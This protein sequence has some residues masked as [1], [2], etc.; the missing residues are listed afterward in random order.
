MEA[1]PRQHGLTIDRFTVSQINEKYD[2]IALIVIATIEI[3][4]SGPSN[5]SMGDDL[6][7]K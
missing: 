3:F 1:L 7:I 6:S 2:R 4:G 5:S